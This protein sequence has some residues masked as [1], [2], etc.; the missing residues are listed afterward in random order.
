V[1][2]SGEGQALRGQVGIFT[3]EPAPSLARTLAATS[4]SGLAAQLNAEIDP[5]GAPAQYFFEYGPTTAYGHVTPVLSAGSGASAEEV[6]AGISD[7]SIL[8]TYHYRLV[9]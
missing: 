5:N 2:V 8:T 3:T 6:S 4:V 7:L 9:A 1:L